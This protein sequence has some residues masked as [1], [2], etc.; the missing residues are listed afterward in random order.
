ML[1]D[2][3]CVC[4]MPWPIAQLHRFHGTEG[5]LQG[6]LHVSTLL[7]AL[8][9]HCSVSHT[10]CVLHGFLCSSRFSVICKVYCVLRGFVYGVCVC[11]RVRAC[12]FVCVRAHVCVCVCSWVLMFSPLGVLRSLSFLCPHIFHVLSFR[13]CAFC[14]R[15]CAHLEVV[16]F[17][18]GFQCSPFGLCVFC[19]VFFVWTVRSF[20]WFAL[21]CSFNI[22]FFGFVCSVLDFLFLCVKMSVF[23]L[24]LSVFCV[25]LFVF[26]VRLCFLCNIF[27]VRWKIFWVLSKFFLYSLWG[28]RMFATSLHS[29]HCGLLVVQMSRILQQLPQRSFMMIKIS[30]GPFLL[31][32][33]R[34]YESEV[35]VPFSFVFWE[36]FHVMGQSFDILC[37]SGRGAIYIYWYWV[38]HVM[39]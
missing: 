3:V 4:D 8:P 28:F 12:K 35:F 39:G 24:K 9:F 13:F 26:R 15:F 22:L 11:V 23:H 36:L 17:H 20:G 31:L 33:T 2:K 27:G 7:S 10:H 21:S 5:V 34:L 14:L 1:Y 16:C 32:F 19:E 30:Y 38:F 6:Q 25:R 29:F 18:W 37:H